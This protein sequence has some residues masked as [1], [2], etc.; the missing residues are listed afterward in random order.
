MAVRKPNIQ[1]CHW[2]SILNIKMKL[3][4]I[5]GII[6]L[7]LLTGGIIWWKTIHKQLIKDK[8]SLH[9]ETESLT[10]QNLK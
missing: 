5:S 3:L 10:K 1:Y 2:I 4:K 7:L 6:L 8:F 9:L